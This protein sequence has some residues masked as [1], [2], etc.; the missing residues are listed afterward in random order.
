DFADDWV[1]VALEEAAHFEALACRLAGLGAAYG[2]LPAHDGLWE[3]AMVTADDLAARLAIVPMTLEARGLETTPPTSKR[4]RDAGDPE[5][6]EFLDEIYRDEIT[7]LAVGVRWFRAACDARGL[8]APAHYA[9]VVRERFTGSLK[10][11]FNLEARTQAGMTE[12][13]LRPW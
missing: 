2:D 1:T 8:D 5:T 9:A 7:H 3:A 12:A 11:P 10:P 4:L 6:A 13:Y